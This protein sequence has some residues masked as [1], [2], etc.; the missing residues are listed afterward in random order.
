MVL[1]RANNVGLWRVLV[2]VCFFGKMLQ[3]MVCVNKE[4]TQRDWWG[5]SKRKINCVA[6]I[7]FLDFAILLS[8]SGAPSHLVSRDATTTIPTQDTTVLGVCDT[9]LGLVVPVAWYICIYP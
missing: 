3:T 1:G 7:C 9:K 8:R 4:F 2:C 6:C 5:K